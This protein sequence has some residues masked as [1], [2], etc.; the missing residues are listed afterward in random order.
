MHCRR[1]FSRRSAAIWK[2]TPLLLLTMP[3]LVAGFGFT[4]HDIE[5]EYGGLYGAFKR[6]Y[7]EHRADWDRL[8]LA[9]VVC[10]P[11]D[12][13]GLDLF[14][15]AVETDVYFCRK[16]VVPLNG[17]P[18]GK[19]LARLPFV[20]LFVEGEETGEKEKRRETGRPPSAQTFLRQ[21]GVPATL[22]RHVVVKGERSAATIVEDCIGGELDRPGAPI[23]EGS[24][25]SPAVPDR[26]VEMRIQSLEIENFRAYRKETED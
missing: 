23:R 25:V 4:S 20:P 11:E 6:Q 8:E 15:S 18:V 16:Y 21:S 22:A 3:Q 24:W 1:R 7:E 17:R 26:A 12:S 9:F 13:P 14:G 10:V 2:E 19:A 5:S